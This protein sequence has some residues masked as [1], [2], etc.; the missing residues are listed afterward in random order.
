MLRLILPLL[1]PS[2]RFFN[3]I[4]PS[5]RIMLRI[6]QGDWQ[7]FCPTPVNIGLW[8]HLCS[9]FYNPTGNKTLFVHSCAVRLFDEL[10]S[11]AVE[12]IELALAQAILALQLPLCDDTAVLSWRVELLEWDSASKITASIVYTAKPRSIEELQQLWRAD[13][14]LCR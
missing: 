11:S 5:P 6:N 3:S 8:A 7:E 2:W 10:D 1:F 13:S 14:K 12:N 4:G 9:V